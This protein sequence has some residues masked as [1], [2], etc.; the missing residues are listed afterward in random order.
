MKTKNFYAVILFV[1]AALTTL[2][3]LIDPSPSLHTIVSETHKQIS[4][5]KNI[6]ANIR[7]TKKELLEVDRKYL[8]I[9]GFPTSTIKPA[10][11]I[12]KSGILE[13]DPVI[14]VPV[15]PAAFEISKTFLASVKKY[16]PE[17][18]IVF[19]DFGLGG[20]ES[21]MVG[22]NGMRCGSH[23]CTLH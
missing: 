12:S 19:Y 1:L 20:K 11:N 5:I 10:M 8:D 23:S 13:L 2:W 6:P 15:F 9:L 16:L 7:H 3:I 4:N 21:L 17:K 18:Y 14:V 22:I